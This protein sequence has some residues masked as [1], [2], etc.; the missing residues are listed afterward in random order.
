MTVVIARVWLTAAI[1]FSQVAMADFE[2]AGPDGRR[3]LLKNDN[4]WSYV[5]EKS[6]KVAEQILLHVESKVDLPTGC[7]FG[8][9]LFSKAPYEIKSLAPEFI[10]YKTGDVIYQTLFKVFSS[11]KPGDSQY[12]EIQFSGSQC[13]A[14]TRVKV[15]GADRC[16]MGDMDKFSDAK[17]ECLAR[18]RVEESNL[19]R[20][21]K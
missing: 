6:N 9:R 20:I 17:G 1:V 7:R 8:L 14:I 15:A 2:V 18:V 19:I 5:D 3:I 21:T 12:Q 4:T 16:Q 13:A 11:V 10:A